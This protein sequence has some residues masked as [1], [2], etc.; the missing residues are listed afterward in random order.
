M[1]GEKPLNIYFHLVWH[2]S[3]HSGQFDVPH[4]DSKVLYRQVVPER[5]KQRERVRDSERVIK[6]K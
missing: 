4:S 3:C 6:K 1:F 5:S 2:E